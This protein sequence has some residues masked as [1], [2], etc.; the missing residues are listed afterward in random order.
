MDPGFIA[1]DPSSL[2]HHLPKGALAMFSHIK[3]TLWGSISTQERNKFFFL[4]LT[5]FL[6]IGTYS[7]LRPLKDAVFMRLVG[8]D[9]IPYA[10]LA[11][12]T[13]L[14]PVIMLYSKLLD[15]LAKHRV[16]YSIAIFYSLAFIG[17]GFFLAHPT[18]GI[19]NTQIHSSRVLGWAFYVITETFSSLMVTLFWSLV[20]SSTDFESAKKGYP[21]IIAGAQIGAIIGPE[22][23]KNASRIGIPN[24]VY[25]VSGILLLTVG[26]VR[27]IKRNSS[28]FAHNQRL[29]KTGPLEGIKLL[30]SRPYLIGIFALTTLPETICMLVEYRLLILADSSFA[31]LEA[32]TEFIAT[33]IQMT[34]CL[35][36]VIALIGTGVIVRTWGLTFSLLLTPLCAGIALIA[37]IL[38]PSLWTFVGT[39]MVI[40]ALGYALNKPCKEMLY[41]PT[42]TAIKFKAKG[43]IDGFGDR[44]SKAFGSTLNAGFNAMG[45][46]HI[47]S[48]VVSCVVIGLLAGS[49][50]SM[51][52]AHA[53][54]MQNNK[55]LS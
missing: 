5:F 47:L 26:L 3:N 50:L 10:K 2:S 12:F 28:V 27:H 24:I 25:I 14:I 22:C 32:M 36:F 41:I 54:L 44:F 51:G 18:I 4:S 8:R 23:A 21:L 20:A 6:I 1:W 19:A 39:L 17:I 31:S 37:S 9:F 33:S 46:L 40:K 45:N 52:K 38:W 16:F 42:S 29:E 48:P 11:S 43:W 30:L 7:I 15:S 53:H 49:A 34:N 35:A 13:C 55:K